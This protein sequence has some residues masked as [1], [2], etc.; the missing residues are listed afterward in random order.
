MISNHKDL[1]RRWCEAS[2]S[3]YSPV[4]QGL[5][6]DTDRL[7]ASLTHPS[8]LETSRIATELLTDFKNQGIKKA[9]Q[10]AKWLGENA[11]KNGEQGKAFRAFHQLFWSILKTK[12]L[13]LDSK[14][15]ETLNYIQSF[16]LRYAT[17]PFDVENTRKLM[18]R[19]HKA[20]ASGDQIST[21]A[22]ISL[23]EDTQLLAEYLEAKQAA[24]QK[25][26]AL[27][28]VVLNAVQ[29]GDAQQL[30]EWLRSHTIK[31]GSEILGAYSSFQYLSNSLDPFK[32]AVLNRIETDAVQKVALQTPNL[33]KQ[34]SELEIALL[35][36]FPLKSVVAF[37]NTNRENRSAISNYFIHLMNRSEDSYRELAQK[38]YKSKKINELEPIIDFLGE[39]NLSK[40]SRLSLY[41]CKPSDVEKIC[42]FKTLKNLDLHWGHVESNQEFLAFNKLNVSSLEN[43]SITNSNNTHL[44][45]VF[46]QHLPNLSTLSIFTKYIVDEDIIHLQNCKKIKNLN[47]VLYLQYDSTIKKL[48]HALQSLSELQTF[49]M[50][51]GLNGQKGWV[52]EQDLTFLDK[53]PNLTT[54]KLRDIVCINKQHL[55]NSDK[56]QT[57]EIIHCKNFNFNCLKWKPIEEL[58]IEFQDNLD[59]S[60]LTSLKKLKDVRIRDI[61]EKI[62]LDFNNENRIKHLVLTRVEVENYNF[63]SKLVHLNEICITDCKNLPKSHLLTNLPIKKITINNLPKT[64]TKLKFIKGCSQAEELTICYCKGITNLD[65]IPQMPELRVLRFD[66]T[67]DL[68]LQDINNI[69]RK[70]PKLVEIEYCRPESQYCSHRELYKPTADGTFVEVLY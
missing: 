23:Y 54:L 8:N 24:G 60:F 5:C 64:V 57:I 28:T 16:A 43:L 12:R 46:L 20:A 4:T 55:I 19:W 50:S 36:T 9:T 30:I 31:R 47:L 2:N 37:K 25:T 21:D 34:I 32:S 33:L 63:I 11:F 40:L 17:P 14:E 29:E 38:L 66:L 59:T 26:T 51:G 18:Q 69:A 3:H 67:I 62:K 1:V 56:L 7:A 41:N 22:R 61:K 48:C 13:Q 45:L 15:A 42:A 49:S 65:F 53:T 70:F 68:N 58:I 10:L 6:E 35:D 39:E 44:P 27:A 52:S